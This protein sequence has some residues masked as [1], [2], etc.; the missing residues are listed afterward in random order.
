MASGKNIDSARNTYGSFTRFAK[1]SA[2]TVAVLVA[3]IVLIIQ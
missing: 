2:I 3:I 1:W